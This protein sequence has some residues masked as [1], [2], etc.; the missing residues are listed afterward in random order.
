MGCHSC[1]GR[2]SCTSRSNPPDLNCR[3]VYNSPDERR[4]ESQDWSWKLLEGW[5]WSLSQWEL[6][7]QQW[8]KR[9]H[10]KGRSLHLPLVL[11]PQTKMQI[12]D[13]LSKSLLTMDKRN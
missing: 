1:S 9:G 7:R 10:N 6:S 5:K 2:S 12:S 3:R 4:G 13:L 11:C 8:K